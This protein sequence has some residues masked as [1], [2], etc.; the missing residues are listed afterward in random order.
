MK[1]KQ[2]YYDELVCSAL[3]GTFPSVMPDGCMYRGF[4]GTKCAAGILI[5]D[6]QY[7]ETMEGCPFDEIYEDLGDIIPKGMTINDV[8]SIQTWHDDLAWYP[9]EFS[10]KFLRKL[11]GSKIFDDVKKLELQKQ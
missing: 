8:C 3:D 6:D 2:E 7:Y 5:P 11:K 10:V 1:T 4:G 9:D